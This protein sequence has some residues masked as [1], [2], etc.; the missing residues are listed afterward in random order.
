MSPVE[1]AVGG[2]GHGRSCGRSEDISGLCEELLRLV[3]ALMIRRWLLWS[4]WSCSQAVGV[5]SGGFSTGGNKVVD[6]IVVCLLFTS[7]K[8][9][10]TLHYSDRLWP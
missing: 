2:R 4:E 3:D 7:P 8:P 10:R 6:G 5:C 9:K 1:A